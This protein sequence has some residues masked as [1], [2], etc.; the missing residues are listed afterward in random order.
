MNVQFQEATLL[1][2]NKEEKSW[3]SSLFREK[4]GTPK[5]EL[6]KT[7]EKTKALELNAM[8]VGMPHVSPKEYKAVIKLLK[9]CHN[10]DNEKLI[11]LNE[12]LS[13]HFTDLKVAGRKQILN[14]IKLATTLI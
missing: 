5:E 4:K 14:D 7:L 12:R 2:D 10:I 1:T 9:N 8:D 11:N 3:F 6:I 13:S